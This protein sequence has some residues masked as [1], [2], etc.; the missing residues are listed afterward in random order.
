MVNASDVAFVVTL[1]GEARS[2]AS[3]SAP[4]DLILAELID[5]AFATVLS[6]E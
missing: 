5:E 3:H 2:N 4:G 6:F 1:I